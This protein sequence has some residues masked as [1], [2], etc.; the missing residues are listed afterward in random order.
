M[1]QFSCR[2]TL[3]Y[4]LLSFKPDTENNENF[5]AQANAPTLMRWNFL[6]HIPKL[7]IFGTHNLQ[8]FKHNTLIN[9]LLLM[10]FYLINICPKLHHRKWRK[11]CVTLPVNTSAVL[12]FLDFT[13]NAVLCS[14]FIRKLCYKLP[15]IVTF[16]FMIHSYLFLIKFLSSLLN[17]VRISAFAW[18]SVIIHVI[19]GVRFERWKVDKKQ[20]Y[21][22]T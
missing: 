19:F 8:T 6:K 1:F 22:K 17:G 20:T 9:K 16:T 10:Q 14:T 21:M 11:L 15:N 18:Y 3:F 5:D 7:I 13:I 4:Q 12:N 2:F